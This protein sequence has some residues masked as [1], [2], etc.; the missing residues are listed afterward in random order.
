[1]N[2]HICS[3][4]KSHKSQASGGFGFEASR[5]GAAG[6]DC[7]GAVLPGVGQAHVPGQR[8]ELD[9]GAK[10]LRMP[11]CEARQRPRDDIEVSAGTTLGSKPY[12]A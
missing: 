11:G 6:F 9:S 8:P 12:K 1:M 3:S 2:L 10:D 7:A 4:R 5:F